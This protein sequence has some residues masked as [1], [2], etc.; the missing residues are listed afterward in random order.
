MIVCDLP[1]PGGPSRMNDFPGLPSGRPRSAM[2][3]PR[4]SGDRRSRRPQGQAPGDQCC[5]G[6]VAGDSTR[7]RTTGRLM[8]R[9]QFVR[10]SRHI[11]RV[12]NWRRARWGGFL[13]PGRMSSW[14]GAGADP[15]NRCQHIL[16]VDAGLVF[17]RI[18]E[19]RYLQPPRHPELLDETVVGG[20]HCAGFSR[21]TRR[22]KGFGP[23]RRE[24]SPVRGEV[25]PGL[26]CFV[27]TTRV[28]EAADRGCPFRSPR[29]LY[30]LGAGVRVAGR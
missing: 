25:E 18:C 15:P 29:G 21:R 1:V 5:R 17:A 24:A 4:R 26:P 2:T 10:R 30:G 9:S 7:C 6:W 16:D 20:P 14:H 8:R 19:F 27:L 12:E 3:D 23:Y 22:R 13:D 11:S 28:L